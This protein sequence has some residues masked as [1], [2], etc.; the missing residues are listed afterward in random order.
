MDPQQRVTLEVTW[1]ALE[2]AGISPQ[3]LAGSNTAV[4]TGVNS[5]DYSKL[6]LEDLPGVEAWMGIGTAYC[7][8]P[9]RISYLLDLRGPSTA[10]DAACAS[11][12]VAVHHGRQSLLTKE[13]DLAI[14]GGVNAI[15][16]PGLTRVLDEAGAISKD[17]ICRSF[18]DS[19]NGYGR[20]EGAGIVILKRM[21]DALRD[22]DR[23]ISVLKG[24]A[25]GQDGRTNGIMAPNG[26]AQEYVARTALGSLD[27][28]TIQYVEAHATSTSVGDPVEI[29]AMAKVYGATRSLS[30]PCLI[31]SV[32]AN[33][34]HLEA[35][36][37]VIGL[38]KAAMSLQK[39]MIPPQASIQKLNQK[40]DWEKSG[41]DVALVPTKWPH[42]NR[43]RRAAV[44]SY[45]YGG[46]VSHAVLEQPPVDNCLS[47]D[48]GASEGKP[49]LLTL[50]AP[51]EKR[52]ADV[53]S[54]LTDWLSKE[55]KKWSLA[56]IEAALSTRRAEHDFR[57]TIIATSHEEAAVELEKLT[58][59]ISSAN[60][61]TARTLGKTDRKDIV[62]LF[63]GHGAQWPQMGQQLL[64]EDETFR[65][66]VENLETLISEEAGF[67]PLHALTRGDFG[68]SDKVQVLTYIMQVALAASLKAKGVR[69]GAVIG[70][71]VG[72]IAASVAAGALSAVEGAVVVCRRARLYK[73]VIGKGAM[74][75]VNQPF[76]DVAAEL[77]G[78]DAVAA[79]DSSPTSCV[80][81]GTVEAID[82]LEKSFQNRQV[83]TF[84]VKSD[85]AFHSPLLE[86]LAKPLR[87][88]L[89]GLLHS[90]TPH[91]KSQYAG[92][93][94]K[95]Y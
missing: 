57:S 28:A 66:T 86:P 73:Q 72:E 51:Q 33:V 21:S 85:I 56:S 70:H 36:A 38:I 48:Q 34:G 65:R 67:S 76:D 60:C 32:K 35:G 24:S 83:K 88:A 79:I 6:L 47:F 26:E 94:C 15:C 46:T 92:F 53:A 75:L 71:S 14:V 18:D 52:L 20:G 39:A 95:H 59:G 3:S 4:F 77:K 12:L 69:P 10:V 8:I 64:T 31:G 2:D 68:S 45:G 81:S 50:S 61:I 7:G 93:L 87:A 55:G 29:G 41:V 43:K 74:I 44:C 82:E 11:S 1:E 17:G 13:T 27:P 30:Q 5:D 80:V 42:T 49:H 63:S 58:K 23:I 40:I 84:R 62:W 37:G 90:R 22:N 25:V 16:G 89:D 19:A 78:G 91:S 9:N 54:S